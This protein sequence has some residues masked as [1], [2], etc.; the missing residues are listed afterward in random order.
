MLAKTIVLI[1]DDPD[2]HEIFQ[3]ALEQV[4][5]SVQCTYFDSSVEALNLLI[6]FP[7]VLPDFVF[8]DL[9]M[10][11]L[12]GIEFLERIKKTHL[13]SLRI[14]IYSTAIIPAHRKKIEELGA[15]R[16]FLKP[17]SDSDLIEILKSVLMD[18]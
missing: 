16:A 18:N 17:T 9:N 11:E 10:P 7:S 3:M 1:D 4:N 12:T 6:D 13:S 5:P 15:Y 14:I 8:L 2:E